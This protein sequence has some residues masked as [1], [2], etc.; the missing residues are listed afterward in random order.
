M[1]EVTP[2]GKETVT[3]EVLEIPDKCTR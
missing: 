3:A 1:T 2:S